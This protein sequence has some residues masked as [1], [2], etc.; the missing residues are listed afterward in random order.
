MPAS[1]IPHLFEC[2]GKPVF[3]GDR[4]HVAPSY[5]RCAGAVVKAYRAPSSGMAFFRSDNGAVPTM[6]I[7]AV[8]WSPHPDVVDKTSHHGHHRPERS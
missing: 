2:E 5:H 1:E 6:P 8:S 4:L 7:S 3:A